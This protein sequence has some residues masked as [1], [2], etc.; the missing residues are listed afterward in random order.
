M[1]VVLAR[2]G[3]AAR[4][5]F[6][7]DGS[8]RGVCLTRTGRRF[9]GE[10]RTLE[11]TLLDRLDRA[12]AKSGL[13][14]ELATSWVVLDAELMPW[15][16][17]A[18]ELLR[19]QYALTGSAG[20]TALTDAVRALEAAAARGLDVGPLLERTRTRRAHLERYVSS[21]RR[22]CWPVA[23]LDDLRVAPFHLLAS[24]GAVHVDRDHLWHLGMLARLAETGDALFVPT[25]HRVVELRDADAVDACIA[26][27]DERTSAGSEGMV[28]KPI[29][30]LPRGKKGLLQ[31][32]IKCRGP[33]YLRIIYG[34]EYPERLDAL[35]QRGLGRKRALA[36]R[37]LA[38][39]V[40]SL[41]RLVRGEPLRRV[42]ECVLA[43]LALE[44]EPVDPRL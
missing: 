16:A 36:L 23:S 8:E 28:V 15:S 6:G 26:W 9:F 42:H 4:R 37:E 39:G 5:R 34:P 17:K 1:L 30:F 41:T 43:V 27:W 31:P 12:L 3:D 2:D 33:E 20:A 10:D 40:E 25:P 44:S 7:V 22:Y 11:A 38:L 29:D 18:Q 13:W 19:D 21:Y 24:E 35:R 32:A 14:D